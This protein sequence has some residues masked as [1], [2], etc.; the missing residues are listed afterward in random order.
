MA[1]PGKPGVPNSVKPKRPKRPSPRSC[2]GPVADLEQH[3]PAEWW[4]KLFN[5]LY[6][7]TDGDVVENV[8]NTRREVDFIVSAAAINPHSQILDLCC[9]QGRHCIEL[10]RRGFKAVTG[11]DR[12]RYLVRL[13]KKRAQTEGLQVVF[14]EGDARNP[15]LPE[16]S[17]DCVAIMGNSFGYF[18]NKQDDER[19]LSTVGKLLR[20]SGQ[21]VLDITDGAFMADHFERR[22]WEWIDEHHFVCRER[23]LSGDRER[24]I[25]REVIVHDEMGVI[26]DQF[27]AERLYTREGIAKLLE[28]CGFRNVRHHGNAEALSDRDQ[29]LGMMARRLLLTADAPQAVARKPKGK[30]QQIDVT[31]L[32]GDPRLPDQ[33]KRGG[34]FNPEDLDT[35]RRLKDALS[36]LKQFKV[37]YFDNHATL[38]RDLADLRTDLVFNLCDEGFNNDAFKEL[39]IPAMLDVLGLPYTGGNPGSLA[40]CYDKGLVRAVAMTLD[41]PV[42]LETYVRP[43]DQGATLPSV[44]PALLKPNHGDSSEG[45]TK[46]A[47]VSNEKALLDY[48]DKLRAMFPRRGVLVQEYLTGQEYSVGLIGNPDQGL[49]ALPILE[50]DYSKLDPNLPRILGYESKWEPDSPYWTQIRYQ[51]AQLAEIQQQQ[52]IEHSAR[53]F[54]RLGCR[55]YARFDFRA[56]AKGEIKLLE[57]NPN[58]GWCW[59]G[60]LNLMAGFQGMRYSELLGQILLAAVERLGIVGRAQPQ[61][62]A[63]QVDAAE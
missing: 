39:H 36:E 34:T 52:L 63:M 17:F 9:G 6:V 38:E 45:I 57:V 48:L 29:D 49:R 42:P 53:M 24:L 21:I 23:S 31:V 25:S 41:V 15:R 8:E 12:S 5:A 20:P 10:A 26:A 18:S 58:P 11:V 40:A 4:R 46:D 59:D 62:G 54:E 55:D 22:S 13:A 2:L 30:V 14:K 3:L 61:T 51:E 19:V 60:K 7:K 50:V 35:V 27:Y 44:F 43:G 47:V 56:D 28:K 32:L 1:I 33:V 37:R 16:G